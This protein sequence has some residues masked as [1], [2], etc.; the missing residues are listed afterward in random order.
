MA[1]D[2][3]ACE[4]RAEALFNR[5]LDIPT[6]RRQAFLIAECPDTQTL[7]LFAT[8]VIPEFR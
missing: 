7:E 2:D 6:D 8:E 3:S 4:R 1:K 5:A